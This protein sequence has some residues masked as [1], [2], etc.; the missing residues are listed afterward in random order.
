MFG[1]RNRTRVTETTKPTLMTRLKGPNARNK[2][3]K[4]E[5][6]RHDNVR[7]A[8]AGAGVGAGV[9][10][11]AGRHSGYGYGRRSRRADNAGVT[12]VARTHHRRK[13]SMGDKISGAMMR[14]RGSMSHRPGEKVCQATSIE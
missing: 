9:G 10:A 12:G 1:R 13:P 8:G 2:T 5:V 11:G 7:T 14:L 6:T 3:Y 4:T